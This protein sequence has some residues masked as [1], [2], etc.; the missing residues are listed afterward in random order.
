M[1]TLPT[2]KAADAGDYRVA[3][4]EDVRGFFGMKPSHSVETLKE[5]ESEESFTESV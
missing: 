4:T 2:K 1:K 5:E 3:V